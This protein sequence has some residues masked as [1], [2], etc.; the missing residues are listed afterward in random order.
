M[1]AFIGRSLLCVVV[2]ALTATQARAQDTSDRE[3]V[4]RAVLDYVEGFYEGDHSKHERSIAP[5]VFK[6]G[7]GKRGEQYVG[8]QMQYPAG[9]V[10]FTE[11]VK[12]GRN[13]PPANPPKDIVIFDVQDQ[14][15]S[16]KLTAWWGTDYLLL[17][18]N[19]GRW[20]ITHVLW[21]S[22]S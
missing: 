12:A 9:F 7:Y 2:L 18:K 17:A 4:R 16:A 6:W 8:M 1:R 5:N 20:Q 22:T 10:A 21:Q 11:G 13:L 14:T 19:N 3:A 15:A